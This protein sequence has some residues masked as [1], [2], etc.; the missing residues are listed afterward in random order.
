[1]DFESSYSKDNVKFPR[2]LVKNSSARLWEMQ[3]VLAEI[4]PFTSEG[5]Q[6]YRKTKD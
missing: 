4:A 6:R 1:M 5:A 2:G 3:A